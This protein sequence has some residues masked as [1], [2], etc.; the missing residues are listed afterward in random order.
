[1]RE[2]FAVARRSFATGGGPF[3]AIIARQDNLIASGM[4]LAEPLHD[5]TAHAEVLA[6]RSA[7]RALKC[8]DLSDCVL[9]SSA[10]PCS[11]CLSAVYWSR[12]PIVYYGTSWRDSAVFG[13]EDLYVYEELGKA[14]PSRAVR[15]QSLLQE[16]ALAVLSD[17]A[18]ERP[19][20]SFL[21]FGWK[22]S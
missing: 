13:Y 5:P 14:P 20:G 9:Y 10:E 21:P 7:A 17:A 4:S 22:P 19:Y 6:I 3:G 18:L 8:I 1:M 2:A 12:I 11:M 16:E 15:C